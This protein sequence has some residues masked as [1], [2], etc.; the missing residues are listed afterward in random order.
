M[1]PAHK[2]HSELVVALT[3]PPM[4]CTGDCN[5]GPCNCSGERRVS[6]YTKES[7]DGL[8]EQ[9]EAALRVVEA[10]RDPYGV[11]WNEEQYTHDPVVSPDLAA[12]L[13]AFDA[14][15]PPGGGRDGYL[16]PNDSNSS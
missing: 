1:T 13:A 11:E 14:G 4:D 9:L 5:Y 15:V 16:A 8:V 10:A 12:A 3:L 7:V 6:A 2:P